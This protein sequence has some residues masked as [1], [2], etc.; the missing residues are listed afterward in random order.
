MRFLYF[1]FLSLLILLGASSCN[2][3]QSTQQPNIILILADDMGYSDLGCF[4]SEILT[5]NLD[6]L[7]KEGMIMTQFYN[8]ARCCPTRASLLT[9]LYPHQAGMGDMVEGRLAPDSSFLPAYQ[10]YLSESCVTLAEVLKDAGYH[11]MMSGKWHVGDEARHW[12][13]ARGFEENY[14][15]IHGATNYFTLEPWFNDEQEI[16]VLD[17]TD[18]VVPGEDYYLTREINRAARRFLERKPQD[19]PFFLYLAHTAPHWPLHALPEDIAL[20]DGYYDQG[21][22]RIRETR[23]QKMMDL[24]ILPENTRLPPAYQRGD[25][26]PDWE[27]LSDEQKEIFARRMEV[28]AAMLY[29]MDVG[30]G[31]ITRWLEKEGELDNTLIMFLSDNGATSALIY[32]AGAWPVDRSGPI[33]S[34]QSFDSQG[35]SWANASN[36]PLRLFKKYTAEGGI[37]TP[38]IASWPRGI[39]PGSLS[40]EPAHIIDLMPTVAEIAGAR[41]PES[42]KGQPITPMEGLSLVPLFKGSSLDTIRPLFFEHSGNRAVRYGPWKLEYQN[43]ERENPENA[44]R[45]YNLDS[46]RTEMIDLSNSHPEKAIELVDMYKA[47]AIRVGVED[48][49]NSLLLARP[50]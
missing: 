45:L 14:A 37:N 7:A 40:R 34:A 41:Y 2:T 27:S 15:L 35:P 20:F 19:K 49:Y 36:T 48:D 3:E 13:H 30:I 33:G 32:L 24:G 38:F 26:T 1:L 18:T 42:L 5:P 28:H 16:L 8:A 50:L 43:S 9:G 11:T 23:F 21:W 46:D 29:R 39:P 17:G 6:R 4:G 25:H 22:D 44:W 12:P 47:W 10:G 31:S